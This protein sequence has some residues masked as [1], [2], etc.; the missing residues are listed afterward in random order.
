MNARARLLSFVGT[1]LL[2][3]PL[4]AAG[5]VAVVTGGGPRRNA[6]LAEMEASGVAFPTGRAPKG[7]ACADGDACD[8]D[9]VRN[10]VCHFLVSVCLNQHGGM[11]SGCGNRGKAV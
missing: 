8:A 5:P 11:I 1:L 4:A 2:A 10:G 3:S 7:V 9:G 6:C